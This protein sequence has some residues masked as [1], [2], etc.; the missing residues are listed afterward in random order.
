MEAGAK[1][2]RRDEDVVRSVG[3]VPVRQL[4]P[5][6]LDGVG[7]QAARVRE[8]GEA[9]GRGEVA[10]DVDGQEEEVG[11]PGALGAP[12]VAEQRLVHGHLGGEEVAR[13]AGVGG[14]PAAVEAG[15]QVVD[16]DPD[17]GSCGGGSAGREGAGLVAEEGGAPERRGGVAERKR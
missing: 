11:V 14:D 5:D 15:G 7:E 13:A 2:V 10:G 16:V 12:G 6:E 3:P 1:V 17:R 4:R 8:R 9:V